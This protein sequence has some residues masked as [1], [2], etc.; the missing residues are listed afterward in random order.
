MLKKVLRVTWM[1]LFNIVC[2][3]EFISGTI[4]AVI[5]IVNMESIDTFIGMTISVI[6]FTLPII[7]WTIKYTLYKERRRKSEEEAE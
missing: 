7:Y 5:F 6:I 3:I 1:V 4:V 2:A